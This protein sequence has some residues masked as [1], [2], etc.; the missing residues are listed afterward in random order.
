MQGELAEIQA[1]YLA[2]CDGD[3]GHSFGI[4]IGTLDNPG[5]SVEIDLEETDL[6]GREFGTIEDLA[7]EREWFICKVAD[8][9]FVGAGGPLMLGHILRTFLDWARREQGQF[10]PPAV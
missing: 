1:W 8:G 4:R 10:V 6:E 7:P 9:K 5:W 3:W 2:Q